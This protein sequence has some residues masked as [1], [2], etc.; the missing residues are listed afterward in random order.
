MKSIAPMVLVDLTALDTPSRTRGIGRYVRALAL[1]I[2]RLGADERA[3]LRIAGLTRLHWTGRFDLTHDLGS[4]EGTQDLLPAKADHRRFAAKRRIALW[5]AVQGAGAALVHLT[6]PNATPLGMGFTRCQ[7]LV[8]C[9]DLIPLQFPERYLNLEDGLQVLGARVIRRR[10][11]SADHILAISDATKAQLETLAG[12]TPDRISRVHNAIALD[13]WRPE[14]EADDARMRERLG[15]E[16]GRY[17]LYVGDTDWRKNVEGMFAG[18]ARA[19]RAGASV[20]L[21]MAGKL[22]AFQQERVARLVERHG[23][24]G[25]VHMA[26]YVTDAELA[27]LYR[28]ALGHLF[29]SRSE[30]FGLTVIEAMACGCPV[31]TTRAGSLAEVAGDAALLVDAEDTEGIAE[32]IVR[33]STDPD[34]R[35]RRIALGSRQAQRFGLEAQAR[36][37]V[38]VYRHVLGI[39]SA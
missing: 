6:D 2:S 14:P 37:T 5:R 7:R 4:F 23:V 10:Y 17:L 36:G 38:G 25:Q 22:N 34:E 24:G 1:G 18:L 32:A 26:G 35:E 13:A 39:R 16:R 12:I 30:G 31:I 3:G 27:G 11:R 19:H 15:I 28:G 8:T 29:V 33:L 21:V 9:H 20:S